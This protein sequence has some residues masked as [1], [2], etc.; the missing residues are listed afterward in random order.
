M[1][2]IPKDHPRYKSLMIRERLVEGFKKGVVVPQGLIAHGRGEAFDYLIGEETIE[3][4]YKAYEASAALLLLSQNPIIAVNGNAAALAYEDIG[5]F[6]EKFNI[7]I[8]INLFH[9]SVE[10]VRKIRELFESFNVKIFDVYD[11]ELP[12][13]SSKRRLVSREGIY[14]SDTVMVMI[15]DGDMPI[16]LRKIGKKVIA[17]DLNPLSRT[18]RDSDITIVDN[19]VR[20]FPILTRYMDKLSRH[21]QDVIRRILEDY[22][23]NEVLKEVLIYI[24]ERLTSPGI[25]D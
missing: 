16:G 22:D 3:P 19:L 8:E 10:R 6:A 25:L 24:V 13:V 14:S 15:E 17:I 11:V 9:F 2:D 23:N 18:A 12:T 21:G 20:V 1:T 4:V 5:R 7:P